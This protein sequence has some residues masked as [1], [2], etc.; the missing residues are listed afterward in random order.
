LSSDEWA[1]RERGKRSA[2]AGSERPAEAGAAG[3]ET[4]RGARRRGAA[5]LGLDAQLDERT[6]AVGRRRRRGR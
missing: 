2:K 4:R 5:A 1:Q 3:R 6:Q